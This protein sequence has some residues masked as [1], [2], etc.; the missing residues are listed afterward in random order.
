MNNSKLITLLRTLSSSELTELGDFVASPYFNKREEVIRLFDFLF[1][2]GPTF[3]DDSLQ[4][5]TAFKYVFPGESYDDKQLAYQMNYL[6]KLSEQFIARKVYES[7]A[8]AEELDTLRG[9]VDR[10]LPKH[11]GFLQKKVE[12]D[13]DGV[14]EKNHIY[15]Q[16][17]LNLKA[18]A[19]DFFTSK[20][21][22][23]ADPSFQELSDALDDYYC[24]EKLRYGC[25]MASLQA[26]VSAE[27]KIGMIDELNEFLDASESIDPHINLYRNLF[28]S[29]RD[30]NDESFWA[31][32]KLLKENQDFVDEEERREMYLLGINYCAKRI[33][34]GESSF[35]NTTLDMYVEGIENRALYEGGHLSHWTFTN[36]VK[37]ALGLKKYELLEN[38]MDQHAANVHPNHQV[39]AEH[40]NRAEL[41]YHK[42]DYPGVLDNL[43]KLE[44]SD[45]YYRLASR[46]LLLKAYH[47]QG[48]VE[49]MLSQLAAF[50]MYLR[51][52]KEISNQMKKPY[53][54]FCQL[55]ALIMRSRPEKINKVREKIQETN[56]VTDKTWL[57]ETLEQELA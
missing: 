30:N 17:Q 31:F 55:L 41:L 57:L 43:N 52:N 23:S 13:I 44:Y 21:K 12:K 48:F 53:L 32:Q 3:D 35:F 40:L 25:T 20:K 51:R 47:A 11:Y 24:F 1:Q 37:L 19:V 38:F 14:Q 4:K 5:D 2:F 16:N 28:L 39:D 36:V 56:P 8:N 18:I 45:F 6:L 27:F 50:T 42:K 7:R 26:F 22:R 29:I 15:W 54:N 49:P 33:R 34:S 9:F 46:L 10:K